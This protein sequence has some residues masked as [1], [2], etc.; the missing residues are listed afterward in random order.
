MKLCITI[1]FGFISLQSYS[2]NEDHKFLNDYIGHMKS[3]YNIE[4]GL[5]LD[6]IYFETT[7]EMSEYTFE[8]SIRPKK[9]SIVV[10]SLGIDA[11]ILNNIKSKDFNI[12]WDSTKLESHN[13][14]LIQLQNAPYENEGL[15]NVDFFKCSKPLII[16][17]YVIISEHDG[18]Y[19][20]HKNGYSC[21]S[22]N[23]RGIHIY[24]WERKTGELELVYDF[25]TA[26]GI[27]CFR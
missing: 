14:V 17:N 22:T 10:D 9:L 13:K 20:Y 5:N 18:S 12:D 21:I 7:Y 27:P 1:F 15:N 2:Q 25:G 24:K 3:K 6:P 19:M 23:A 16:E 8:K 26:I 4:Y 11:S